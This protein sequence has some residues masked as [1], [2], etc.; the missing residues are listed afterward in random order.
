MPELAAGAIVTALGG[1]AVVGT[2]GVALIEI[3]VGLAISTAV[4]ALMSKQ[5]DQVKTP[6]IKTQFTG[7]GDVTPQ[8]TILGKYATAGHMIAPYYCHERPEIVG[9][10]LA[11]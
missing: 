3:G 6:G 5:Q 1:A 10:E 9:V 11:L 8:S 7:Q 4:S 2:V